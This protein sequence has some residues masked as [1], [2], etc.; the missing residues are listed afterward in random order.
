MKAEESVEID[1]SIPCRGGGW[2]WYRDGGPEIVITLFAV[3]HYDVQP[4]GSAT[5]E[6]GDQHLFPGSGSAFG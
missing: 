1:G 4:I 3:R 6:D 2:P 5:L